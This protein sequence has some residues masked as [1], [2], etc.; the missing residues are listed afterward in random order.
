MTILYKGK[1]YLLVDGN[2]VN[3]DNIG[4]NRENCKNC[5]YYCNEVDKKFNL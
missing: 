4:C 5:K 2:Y 3:E 1:I